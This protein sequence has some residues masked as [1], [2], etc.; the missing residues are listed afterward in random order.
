MG[1]TK[2]LSQSLLW[3]FVAILFLIG[4]GSGICRAKGGASGPLISFLPSDRNLAADGF[5]NIFKLIAAHWNIYSG[6]TIYKIAAGQGPFCAL[7]A[8]LGGTLSI[9]LSPLWLLISPFTI[10]AKEG[11]GNFFGRWSSPIL[12]LGWILPWILFFISWTLSVLLKSLN[13][14]FFFAALIGVAS[15]VSF[16]DKEGSKY[17]T[18]APALALGGIIVSLFLMKA[19]PDVPA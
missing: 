19:R 13:P 4:I 15:I 16:Y 2:Q 9:L 11:A 18:F 14:I 10:I 17:Y 8:G 12:L 7:V 1:D 5:A 6:R 3:V